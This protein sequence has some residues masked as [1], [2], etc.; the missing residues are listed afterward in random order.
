MSLSDPRTSEAKPRT[1]RETCD[2]TLAGEL[3]PGKTL[4]IWGEDVGRGPDGEA[5]LGSL[6]EI[7]EALDC[8]AEGGG[9]FSV[10]SGSNA[11]GI[12]RGRLPA[13]ASAPGSRRAERGRDLEQI[14][15]GLLDGELDGLIL[16]HADPIRELPDGPGWTEALRRARTV[17]AISAFD[18]ASTKAADV[19][20]PAEAY[21]EKEGTVTHPDGRLQ[22]LRPSV[23]RPGA[24][25]ADVAGARRSSPPR[26]ATRP[27][28]SRRPTRWRRSRPRCRS[29]PG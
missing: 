5:A 25:A 2:A 19:V 22:R 3:R 12:A 14:K 11:R 20:L 17:V 26:S 10:P 28:S 16:V 27:G 18:D 4:V 8:S 15:Q 9:A 29:T 6:L 23:P 13:R 1:W 21:A 24:G 7:C